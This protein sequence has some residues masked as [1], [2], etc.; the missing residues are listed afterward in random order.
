MGDIFV[1]SRVLFYVDDQTIMCQ[2]NYIT[3]I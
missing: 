1:T 3:S 2:E